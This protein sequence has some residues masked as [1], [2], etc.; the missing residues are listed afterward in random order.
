M[1]VFFFILFFG[2]AR[3]I[4]FILA[5]ILYLIVVTPFTFLPHIP[6]WLMKILFFISKLWMRTCL[7]MFGVIWVKK[8][9][10]FDPKTRQLS[11]NHTAPMDGHILFLFQEFSVVIMSAVQ[12]VPCFGRILKAAGA[13]FINREQSGSGNAAIIKAGIE[14]HRKLPVALAPEGKITNGDY[15]FKFR[16]GGFLTDEQ[17]QPV[18]VRYYRL[19]PWAGA[20]LSWLCPSFYEW[21]WNCISAP[22]FIAHLTM[23]P[24]IRQE[25]L[26]DKSPE[27]RADM[28]QLIIANFLGTLAINR[29][30]REFFESKPH[31]E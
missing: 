28:T 16:S 23:L 26:K 2:W 10:K 22:G 18:A 24:P 27:Q 6:W 19:F 17:I 21:V 9:G 31:G 20:S 4:L 11:Y 1:Q 25:E 7:L 13:V 8:D 5:T 14:D 15:M 30:S 12:A 29:S 3:M